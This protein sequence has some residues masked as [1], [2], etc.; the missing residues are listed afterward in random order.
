MKLLI[1]SLVLFLVL[2]TTVFATDNLTVSSIE[3]LSFKDKTIFSPDMAF[4]WNFQ[5]GVEEL[6]RFVK[7]TPL[8]R[9]EYSLELSERRI[10]EMEV[11]TTKN[12]SNIIPMIENE[13]ELEIDKVQSNLNSTD[14]FSKFIGPVN[15]DIKE[16][17]TQRLD[18]DNK[19]LDIIS[20]NSTE[21]AKTSLASAI[22]K[23]SSCIDFINK[24]G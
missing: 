11:L 8:L 2:L 18:Y 13:Y 15:L 6:Y 10:G 9:I 1:V 3:S 21:P 19:V 24:M 20:K 4:L 16:N 7:F 23:T 22:K 12:E 5:R 14:I 17:V